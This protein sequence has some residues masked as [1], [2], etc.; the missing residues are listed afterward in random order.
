M[1][2]IKIFFQKGIIIQKRAPSIIFFF[3]GG[4]GGGAGPGHMEC[5]LEAALLLV[6]TRESGENVQFDT[7]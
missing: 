7:C 5:I 6:K 1:V 2:T 3:F 4:G